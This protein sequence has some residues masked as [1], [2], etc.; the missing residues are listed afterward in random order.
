MGLLEA[1]YPD[2]QSIAECRWCVHVDLFGSPT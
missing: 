1:E 2:E